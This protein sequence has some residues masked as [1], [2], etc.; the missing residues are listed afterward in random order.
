M[1]DQKV[2]EIY[3]D[4]DV[5]TGYMLAEDWL[6]TTADG[7]LGHFVGAAAAM[8]DARY[9]QSR[10]C[11]SSKPQGYRM[12]KSGEYM[13]PARKNAQAHFWVISGL[14]DADLAYQESA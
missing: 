6:P 7:L 5:T 11:L 9:D 8:W 13:V 4:E 10:L 2:A 14:D 12:H 3:S 1:T